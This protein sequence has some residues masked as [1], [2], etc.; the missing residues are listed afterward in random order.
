MVVAIL[1]GLS[2]DKPHI[3]YVK[4]IKVNGNFVAANKYNRPFLCKWT[5]FTRI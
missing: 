2:K 3:N 5:A 1:I 4:I